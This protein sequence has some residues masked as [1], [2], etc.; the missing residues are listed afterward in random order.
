MSFNNAITL[1][2]AGDQGILLGVVYL[3]KK[4]SHGI[5]I[6][7]LKYGDHGLLPHPP[8]SLNPSMSMVKGNI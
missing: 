2:E 7:G 6:F 4:S 1:S 3:L 5:L 8:S